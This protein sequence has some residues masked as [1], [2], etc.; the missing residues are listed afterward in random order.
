MRIAVCVKQVPDSGTVS[1]DPETHT[2]VRASV[3]VM[4]NPL[5]E[6]PLEIAL[7][8]KDA[9]GAKVTV[10]TMGPPRAEETLARAIAMGADEGV[11]LTDAKFAGGDTWATSIVLAEAIRKHGP[12]DLALFGKQAIDGDTAQVG[13]EAAAHLGWPQ[14]AGVSAVAAPDSP[15]PS[16]L[17]VTRLFEDGSDE[18]EL[19]LPAVMM[20]LKEAAEPR[21]GTL[22]GRLDYFR[23]GVTKS[24]SGVLGLKP[25]GIGLKGS[26][27]RVVKT[28]IPS[29]SRKLKRLQGT[30]VS[31]AAEL[32]SLLKERV[33]AD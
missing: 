21:F 12:F 27:T 25:D 10:F 30:P 29:V 2:L 20:V 15:N 19:P 6:F 8:L 28:A 14:A 7:K 13:P 3:G 22:D 4:L 23:R 18:V 24:N 33:A 5:D 9:V 31:Q 11:L 32:A 1:L 16:S 17:R 26:P